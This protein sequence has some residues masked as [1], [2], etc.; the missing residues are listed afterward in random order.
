MTVRFSA[1]AAD[2]LM[3]CPGSANLP[4]AIPGW[5]EPVRDDM[6]GAK[7]VGTSV[8]AVLAEILQWDDVEMTL[9]ADL[10][11]EFQGL[12]YTKRN[13]ILETDATIVAYLTSDPQNNWRR[14]QTYLQDKPI[15][16]LRICSAFTPKMMRFIAAATLEVEALFDENFSNWASE[17]SYDVT[18]LKGKPQTTPD[19]WI[20]YA[21]TNHLEVVDFKTGVIPVPA[22]ENQQL[23]YYAATVMHEEGFTP[24]TITVRIMQPDHMSDCTM[25]RAELLA[26]M[27]EARA[28][29]QRIL[30]KDLTL[31]PT[32]KGCK[33]CP[34]NPH[35]RGD[36]GTPLCPAMMDVLYPPVIDLEIYEAL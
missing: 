16:I 12:H 8:H 32:D 6:A 22:E 20:Y 21:K 25:N 11:T 1:S 5:Q 26:W 24:S 27:D 34:A 18:W 9:F 13:K 14:L 15:E 23:M 29:E 4:L 7:G 2:R 35:T 33:F 36:K 3:A 17:R 31:N 28:A 10:L 19:L 30:N